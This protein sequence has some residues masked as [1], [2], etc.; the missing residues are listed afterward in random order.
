MPLDI[1]ITTEQQVRI[2]ATPVTASGNPAALDGAL[3]V[4]VISGTA[5]GESD[6]ANPLRVILRASDTPGATTFL[7][8][9]DADLGAG[10]VLIQ[11]TA[12]LTVIGAMAS[13]L[14]L[15]VG[16]PEPKDVIIDL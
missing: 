10:V 14:G 5:T 16:T 3:R 8:E 15:V 2:T 9:G 11:D 6:P 1:S 4:S 13:S 7:I 12:T